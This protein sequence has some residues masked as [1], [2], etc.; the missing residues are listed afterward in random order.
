MKATIPALLNYACDAFGEAGYLF[1]KT[2][3]GWVGTS[4]IDARASA[5][6]LAVSLVSHGLIGN[7]AILSENR[8][9]WVISELG[10]LLSGGTTVPLSM[11]LLPEEIPFRINHSESKALVISRNTSEKTMSV[12]AQYENK[13]KII[14]LDHDE[15]LL[16]EIAEKQGLKRGENLLSYEDL[17]REGQEAL[18][19]P[20]G[21]N[22]MKE[23]EDSIQ[24][25]DPATICYTSGTTGNPK[26]AMLSHKNFYR[27]V[28]QATDLFYIPYGLKTLVILPVD[29][30]YAHTIALY[31]SLIRKF[32][33]Y[34]VDA[35]GGNMSILRNIPINLKEV[36]P[37]FLLTVPSLTQNFMNRMLTGIRKKG[38]FIEKLF[39]AGLA[40]KIAAHGDAWKARPNPIARFFHHLAALPASILVFPKLRD[41]FGGKLRFCISGGAYLDVSQQQFFKAIGLPVYQGYGLT[42]AS[43]VISTNRE[44]LHRIGTAGNILPDIDV[45]VIDDKG[46]DLPRGQKGEILIKGDNVMLGYFKNPDASA[47]T[48]QDG[49]LHT[50]DLGLLDEDGFLSVMGRE[51]ALLIAADGEKYSPEEIEEAVVNTAPMLSQCMLYCDHR[52]YVSA[53]ISLDEESV[54]YTIERKKLKGPED[55]LGELQAEF[56]AYLEHPSYKD[57]FPKVWTPKTFLVLTEA[58]SEANKMINSTLK[59]VRHKVVEVHADDIEYMYS[60]EGEKAQNPRNLAALQEL[61]FSK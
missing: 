46:K 23:I 32:S 28:H 22:R 16:K 55:L 53:L 2:D 42:E 35:R 34:F 10:I 7:I 47:E 20:A 26:G 4:Y 49:W 3:A 59:L 61:Y 9:Q 8:P 24:E 33:L 11:K 45:R 30:S 1:E 39:K 38:E 31:A 60:D 37:D 44:G 17:L 50:G 13:P 58:F 25:Q 51:K 56:N 52:K 5:K 12:Y 18:K 57:R 19:D 54:R 15:D 48:I 36:K 40:H 14:L 41:A 27:N 21:A 43:P 29:H 6:A